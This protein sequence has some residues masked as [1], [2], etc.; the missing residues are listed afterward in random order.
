MIDQLID[1]P[2][3]PAIPGLRFRTFDPERD[4]EAYVAVLRSANIA[5]DLEWIPTVE[6][7]RHEHEHLD[8]FDPRR[9]ILLAE[10]DGTVVATAETDVRTRDGE[11][12]HRVDGFVVPAWRRRGLGRAMLH[13]TERRAAEVAGVD[14]RSGNRAL[15]AHPDSQQAG[16]VA[17]YEGEGYRA[18][19]YGFLMVRDL[20]EAIP[21]RSLPAGLVVRP[22]DVAHHRAIWDADVEAFRDHP[23]RAEVTESDFIR[24]FSMPELDTSLWRV[25]WDGDEVAGSVMTFVYPEENA[26]LGQRRGWLEHVSVR[27]PWRRRGV[28]SALIVDALGAL[29]D[30]GLSEAALGVDAENPTGALGV[31]EALGFRQARTGVLY[32]KDVTVG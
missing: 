8:E 24:W 5:D 25:A 28:G 15:A 12:V 20:T 21:D 18:V 3:A 10:I 1:L 30:A 14:G 2:D 7:T 27:R 32:R 6:S 16:A 26:T 22:V 23:N 11:A 4:Y 13:W 17:L 9:D 31:Y 19:R 29:R